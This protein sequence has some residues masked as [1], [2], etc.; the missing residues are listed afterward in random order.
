VFQQKSLHPFKNLSFRTAFFAVRN[1]PFQRMQRTFFKGGAMLPEKKAVNLKTVAARVGLAPCSVSAV[2]NNT[3]AA[4]AIPQKTKDRIHR[5]A[6]ELNYRPNIVARSLR[7]KRTRM[8]A[9]IA[10]GLGRSG[11]AHVVA[12]AQR[13]LHQSG[14]LL[15]L[16]TSDGD[17]PNHLCAQFQQRGIEGVISIDANLPAQMNMPVT[18][19]DLGY[20]MSD[21]PV[22]DQA[23]V[24][25]PDLGSTAAETIMRQIE[26][27][28]SSQQLH[29]QAMPP[30]Y[31]DLPSMDRGFSAA[32]SA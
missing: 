5:A 14:Y 15:V 25:L 10:P 24:W 22:S 2:L 26:N 3:K 6:A 18:S 8:V 9:V 21:A 13:R 19:V 28:G 29:I 30:A 20:K 27:E 1:L 12:A 16:A 7:T 31:V 17:G 11:V 32:E 23:E 4:R